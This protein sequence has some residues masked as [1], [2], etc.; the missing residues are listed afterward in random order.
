[1]QVRVME[2][3]LA[4]RVEHGEEADVCTQ[5]LGIGSDGAQRL[6]HRPKKNVVDVFFVL[7]G[8]RCNGFRHREDNVEILS[9]EKLGAA[10]LQPPGTSKRLA[11]WTMPIAA[12]V[13]TDALVVTPIALLDMTTKCRCS[14]QLNRTHDATL[15]GAERRA[16]AQTIGFTVAAEE[17][18]H[19]R[20]TAGHCR[21]SEAFG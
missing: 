9:V 11:L 6:A 5:V 16:M 15:C 21:P 19:F 10:V 20:P 4:P 12:T 18:R 2:E 17:I 13:E 7:E 1:M 3:I 14:A 8:N